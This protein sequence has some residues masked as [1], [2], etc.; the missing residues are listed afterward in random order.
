MAE[1]ELKGTH[2]DH[3]DAEKTKAIGGEKN[4]RPADKSGVGDKQRDTSLEVKPEVAPAG[5]VNKEDISDLF[6]SAGLELTEDFKGK[7][8][9]LVETV[10][11]TRVEEIKV[12]LKEKF[13]EDTQAHKDYLEEKLS[14]YLEIFASK[15]IKENELAVDNGIKAEIADSLL[16]GLVDLVKEHNIEIEEDKVDVINM[17]SERNAELEAEQ[18][19]LLKEMVN[20]RKELETYKKKEIIEEMATG[21]DET[22]KEKLFSLSENVDFDDKEQFIET[23]LS[24]KD[25]LGSKAKTKTNDTLNE[26]VDVDTETKVTDPRISKYLSS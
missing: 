11:A 8:V 14:D 20:S 22:S 9:T 13:E 12:N 7:A 25:T 3:T 10:I 1:K 2:A 4:K 16:E 21:L 17:L 15:F 6:S 23:M 5:K 26:G 19:D 24:L 18:N